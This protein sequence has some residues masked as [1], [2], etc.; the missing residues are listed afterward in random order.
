MHQA[1]IYHADLHL[2]NFLVEEKKEIVYLIDFDKST[3]SP[4]LHP[5]Q[6]MK[7]L[8][9]LDR[10]AEKLKRLGLPLTGRDKGVFCRAYASGDREIRPYLHAYLKSYRWYQWLY[11]GGW[12]IARVLYP[13]SKPWRKS[14]TESANRSSIPHQK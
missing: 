2:K 9:R 7:N 5:S 13:R 1:G 11:R 10:S 8:K 14:T 3:S 6:R 12:W 4:R